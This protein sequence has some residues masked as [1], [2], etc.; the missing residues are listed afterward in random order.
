MGERRGD[1][2]RS[3]AQDAPDVG[4]GAVRLE[5]GGETSRGIRDLQDAIFRSKVA[6]ARR[7]PMSRKLADGPRLFD[8][9]LEIMRGA[10]RTEHPEYSPAQV[11]QEV[12]RR[13]GIARRIDDAGLYRDVEP[14]DE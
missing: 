7:T 6:R 13:V 8:E 3:G 14:F 5:D 9:S 1:A 2:D 10:I 4:D 11:E 12:R